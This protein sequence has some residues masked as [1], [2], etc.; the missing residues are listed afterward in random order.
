MTNPEFYAQI[1]EVPKTNECLLS[2]PLEMIKALDWQENDKLEWKQVGNDFIINNI[3]AE[4]R[5]K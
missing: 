1:V 4:Q 3:S 5:K 2:F